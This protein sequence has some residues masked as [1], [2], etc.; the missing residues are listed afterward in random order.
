MSE[1]DSILSFKPLDKQVGGPLWIGCKGVQD[2][3]H[4]V[5]CPQCKEGHRLGHMDWETIVCGACQFEIPNPDK[6]NITQLVE[7]RG[8]VYGH[9]LDDFRRIAAIEEVIAEC[10]DPEIRHAIRMVWV[11][12]CRLIETPDHKDSIDDIEG[13]AK[14]MHMVHAERKVRNIKGK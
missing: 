11:K 9:P 4:R 10:K 3:R 1:E 2:M 5:V 7:E 6:N 8:S 14:T 12:C 13:Y